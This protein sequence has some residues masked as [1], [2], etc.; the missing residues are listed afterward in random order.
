M[1]PAAPPVSRAWLVNAGLWFVF[2]LAFGPGNLLVLTPT[3]TIVPWVVQ[4]RK[5]TWLGVLLHAAL[6]LPG[7]IAMG[8]GAV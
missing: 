6:S 4:R 5:N 3:I 7:F 8:L 2:H 1:A